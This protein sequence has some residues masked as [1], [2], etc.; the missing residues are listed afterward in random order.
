MKCVFHKNRNILLHN[1]NIVTSFS[2]CNWSPALQLTRDAFILSAARW[3]LGGHFPPSA[4]DPVQWPVRCT[5]NI[6]LALF[7]LG[8]LHGLLGFLIFWKNS[9]YPLF[10]Q[11][12]IL[13]IWGCLLLPHAFIQVTHFHAEYNTGGVEVFSGLAREA[14]DIHWGC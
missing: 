10:W 8:H 14:Y 13:L 1:H 6:S 9:T 3:G 2:K 7:N 5:V 12:R 11:I 4:W